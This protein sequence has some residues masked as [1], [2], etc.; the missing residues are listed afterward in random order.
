VTTHAGDLPE[1]TEDAF[2]GGALTIAQPRRGY[3]A[4]LDAVLLAA[5]CPAQVRDR[6]LDAGAGV[7]T[8]GLAIARRTGADVTLVEAQPAL[9]RL[10]TA[11]VARNALGAHVGVICADV[12]TSLSRSDLAPLIATFDHVVANPPYHA[13]HAG[14]RATD[15]FKDGSHAMERGVLDHWLRCLAALA[16][17]G[18]RLTL[19]HRADALPAILTAIDRRF[20][21][22]AVTPIQPRIEQDAHRVVVTG[23]KGSRAPLSLRPAIVLHESDGR[24]R[25]EI[26]AMLRSGAGL[27]GPRG[28]DL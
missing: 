1:T 24:Y 14:T 28:G 4:G 20:G 9:A 7:G 3:R 11:N 22:L 13:A 25:A 21:A 23:L 2:L 12:T 15:P 17:P 18:G 8:V 5:A 27:P 26:D 19:I 6:V 16:R 10:A